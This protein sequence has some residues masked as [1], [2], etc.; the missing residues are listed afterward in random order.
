MFAHI[1][2]ATGTPIQRSNCHPFR[3]DDWLWMHNGAI[4]EFRGQA[5]SGDGGGFLALRRHRGLDGLGDAVLPG[6]DV[7]SWTT[8]RPRRSPGPSGSSRHAGGAGRRLPVPGHD[9]HH[10]RGEP[11]GI[12]L[13]QR[14]QVTVAVL[15]PRRRTL[16]EQYPDREIL[17]E[18]SDDARLVV[19][20]PVG[21]LPGAWVEMPEA[22]YG[23]V[24]T[25]GDEL[26]PFAPGPRRRPRKS[27][28]L[29]WLSTLGEGSAYWK[30]RPPGRRG[31]G[32]CGAA[33]ARRDRRRPVHRPGCR[34]A[35]SPGHR[36]QSRGDR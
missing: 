8:T 30:A 14:G 34:C 17:R 3:H 15:H 27:H 24:S 29:P 22:S 20:E 32:R 23:V 2:A 31:P 10:R 7:R 11:V 4:R 26:L 9:R 25:G 35:D 21:E 1:R 6:P 5:R 19:S 36:C 18:V 28:V 13:L 12:P 16:R 33:G